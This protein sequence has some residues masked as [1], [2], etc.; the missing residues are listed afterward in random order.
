MDDDESLF[1]SPPP[2]PTS[3]RPP[4]PAWALPGLTANIVNFNLNNCTAQNVGTIAL[5]GSHNVSELPVNP[6]ALSLSYLSSQGGDA[7][8]PPTQRSGTPV[9]LPNS[10]LA[11]SGLVPPSLSKKKTSK[12]PKVKTASEAP[13]P[14][15]PPI[16]LPDPSQ[17]HP[18]P[19]NLL[20]NQPGLL[21]TAGVVAGIRPSQLPAHSV[22]TRG[23]TPSNP[24]I[25]DDEAQPPPA[26][27][28]KK[29][30]RISI[31][32]MKLSPPSPHE[33]VSAL[34]EQ[35]D[36]F[37]LLE[38]ILKLIAQGSS[39]SSSSRSPSQSHY[40]SDAGSRAQ[41]PNDDQ[42]FARKRRKLRHVPAG[43]DLW[44]VPFPFVEGEGPE[45]YHA[46]WER[47]RGKKMIAELVALIKSAA[48]KAAK[49]SYLEKRKT[50]TDTELATLSK[51]YRI[52]TLFYPKLSEILADA[53]NGSTSSATISSNTLLSPSPASPLLSLPVDAAKP[54]PFEQ[55]ISSLLSNDQFSIES[56]SSSSDGL[57][58]PSSTLD[59]GLF[60][61]WMDILQT[62]PVPPEGFT[63]DFL[64]PDEPSNVFTSVST[65]VDDAHALFFDLPPDV[66]G[67]FLPATEFQPFD[68]SMV[69]PVLLALSDSTLPVNTDM[70]PYLDGGCP[71]LVASP[72]PS[73]CSFSTW[74]LTPSEVG[75]GEAGIVFSGDDAVQVTMEP[76]PTVPQAG[77]ALDK[78]KKRDLGWTNAEREA[79]KFLE[80]LSKLNPEKANANE[81]GGRD[82]PGVMGHPGDK[83][84]RDDEFAKVPTLRIVGS[85]AKAD[86]L[87]RAKERREELVRE[88]ADTKM[89]LWE[90][91]IE[92]GVLAGIVERYSKN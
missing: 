4:S 67:A 62:F 66:A 23:S 83:D 33:I 30:P 15:P 60:N 72:I 8:R 74:P 76:E 14:T 41:T 17:S 49:K 87:R 64:D 80:V 50:P 31:D 6:L 90:T 48:R 75:W 32:Y 85:L 26:S 91:T 38:S 16:L 79:L 45:T 7:P 13:R 68:D 5:P 51:H 82:G 70:N 52:D 20:R 61:S 56:G 34:V 21:G 39:R 19:P 88:I 47:D 36:V 12:K 25:V 28:A 55:L 2:S 3:G 54:T 43:A 11:P 35:R 53:S 46:D 37:P 71:S 57:P 78:G 58:A 44:D 18:L 22:P 59:P 86:A 69:D 84:A 9:G 40:P 29:S 81:E 1:G 77:V 65:P 73:D 42:A 63:P 10:N 89:T 24:I 92:G 27:R